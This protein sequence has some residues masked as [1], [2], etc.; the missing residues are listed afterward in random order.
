MATSSGVTIDLVYEFDG[1]SPGGT[2]SFGTVMLVQNG[3]LVDV[4][5]TANTANLSGGDIHEFYFN[6]PDTINAND[7]V[8]SNSGGT[9][10][11]PI[12]TFTLLGPNPSIA[13][14]GGAS[15]DTGVS[16]GNGGGPPG[17]G[18]LTAATFSLTVA[19]GLLVGDLVPELST[20]NN[21]PPV[22]L[23]VHFQDTDIFGADSETV[24]GMVPEPSSVALL[25]LG[26]GGLAVRSHR[27]R[28]AG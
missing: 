15:F 20:P 1:N 24:G 27:D 9:S 6:L 17:N 16:F 4:T 21:T 25:A 23:A 18:I 5:I 10:D 19:G 26:L 12:G 13:G 7:L 22:H 14:G 11:R 28:T 2:T 8:L 3:G